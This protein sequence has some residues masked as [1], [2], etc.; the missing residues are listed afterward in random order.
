MPGPVSQYIFKYQLKGTQNDDGEEYERIAE[1]T[2]KALSKTQLHVQSD[3]SQAIGRILAA[4]FA[5]QKTNIV[6]PTMAS[7]LTRHK[8]RFIMSHEFIWCPYRDIEALLKNEQTSASI[9]YNGD[10]PFFQCYALHYLCRPLQLESVNA[11]DFFT[12]Y[13]VIRSKRDNEDQLLPFHNGLWQHPSY[14]Q[15][16]NRFLQ[17]VRQRS[18]EHLLTVFQCDFPN[19]AEFEGPIM[20][21]DSVI[22]EAM[23]SYSKLALLLFLPYRSLNDILIDGSYTRKFR[24]AY[25]TGLIREK[26]KIFLQNIQDVRSN[27]SC[28]SKLEDDLQRNTVAYQSQRQLFD[29]QSID[30]ITDDESNEEPNSEQLDHLNWK[31]MIML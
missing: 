2:R 31:V 18:K 6:G 9:L 1:A 16:G 11:Y 27:C 30:N 20:S 5:H 7:Y 13:E 4:S 26:D 17:G 24:E 3:R 21:L 22:T 14:Q 10:T 28:I 19:S 25:W 23:E 15:N 8:S 12:Q 29:D